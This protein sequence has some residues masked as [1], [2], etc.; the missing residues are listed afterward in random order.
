MAIKNFWSLQAGEAI[1][2]D[3][4]KRNIG[5]KYELFMPLNNQLKNFDLVL[6]NLN[7]R[8]IATIQVKESREYTLGKGNG[9]FRISKEKVEN[10][11]A[12]FYIFLIYIS[13][14]YE[15]KSKIEAKTLIVPSGILLEKSKDKKTSKG[16]YTYYFKIQGRRSYEDRD[17]RKHPIDYSDYTDN[18][19]LLEI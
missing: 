16:K 5:K 11:V 18:F 19:G 13:K 14:K 1:A 4:I 12:D 10:K 9:W 17:N 8:K 2:I 6:M 7:T 15:N 3:L